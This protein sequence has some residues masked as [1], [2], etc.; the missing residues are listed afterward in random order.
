M[1]IKYF[2]IT[3]NL[4][5]NQVCLIKASELWYKMLVHYYFF[6]LYIGNGG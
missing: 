4:L 6:K 5:V 1:N 3:K 2:W